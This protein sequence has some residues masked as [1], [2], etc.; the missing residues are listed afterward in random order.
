MKRC[1]SNV[2]S[3]ALRSTGTL[4]IITFCINQF[5]YTIV[6][7]KASILWGGEDVSMRACVCFSEYVCSQSFTRWARL[8]CRDHHANYDYS[9][10]RMHWGK[11]SVGGERHHALLRH[12]ARSAAQHLRLRVKKTYT[13]LSVSHNQVH[14]CLPPQANGICFQLLLACF[15]CRATAG[16]PEPSVIAFRRCEVEVRRGG[17]SEAKVGD[18]SGNINLILP[19][20]ER[21]STMAAQNGRAQG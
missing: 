13:T 15:C 21:V 19:Q 6:C 20:V 18:E 16:L 2:P 8:A 11:C 9:K 12:D 5:L 3:F 14:N 17:G 7:C 4:S 1:Y 10:P